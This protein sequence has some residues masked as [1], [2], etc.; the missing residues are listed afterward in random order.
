MIFDDKKKTKVMELVA[1][2]KVSEK[3]IPNFC[4]MYFEVP[5]RQLSDA[6]MNLHQYI[7]K[8]Y[9]KFTDASDHT[10]SP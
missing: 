5:E 3:K 10:Y 8:R 6:V 2:N 4:Y 9:S 1:K 7:Y